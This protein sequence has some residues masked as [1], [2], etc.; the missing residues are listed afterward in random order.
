M[1]LEAAVS[2]GS[3]DE[4]QMIDSLSATNVTMPHTPE[5]PQTQL[6]GNEACFSHGITSGAVGNKK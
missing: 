1:V 5:R 2:R 3:G 4:T 6:E